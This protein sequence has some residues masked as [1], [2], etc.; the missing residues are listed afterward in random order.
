MRDRAWILL[1]LVAFLL[2]LTS[3][4]WWNMRA[5]A[6]L[7]GPDLVLPADQKDC[8]LPA[9]EMNVSHMQL[10]LQWRDEVVRQEIHSF[11]AY[12]GKVYDMRLSGTCLS[13]H[14]KAKFCDRCHNYVGVKTPY[15]WDCHIDPAETRPA[16]A[17]RSP[18]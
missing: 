12:D 17:R 1:G 15:C 3:P 14:E 9:H 16:L 6:G 11:K 18:Q 2:L 10:L 4:L 7:K 5:R 13:C 8:V